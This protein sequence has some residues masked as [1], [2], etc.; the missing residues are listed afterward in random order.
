MVSNLITISG[1][2]VKKAQCFQIDVH[3]GYG[4]VTWSYFYWQYQLYIY[5]WSLTS[6]GTL[7]DA[8]IWSD[9]SPVGW[10]LIVLS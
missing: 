9:G 7:L 4:I 8:E 3:D 10:V 6:Q 5:V 1:D 2:D